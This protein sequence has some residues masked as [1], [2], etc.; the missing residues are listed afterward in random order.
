MTIEYKNA[1]IIDIIDIMKLKKL[2]V[3]NKN[4]NILYYAYK[5]KKKIV[6]FKMFEVFNFIIL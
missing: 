4:K 2:S 5:I 6:K 3:E 1:I